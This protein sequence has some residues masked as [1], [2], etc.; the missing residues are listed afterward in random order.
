MQAA[1]GATAPRAKSVLL[2]YTMGGISHHDSFDPKPDAPVEIRGEFGTIPT[3]VPG[4]RFSDYVPRLARQIN[5]YTLLRSIYHSE[6]DHGV[7]AY[8]MLRG[9]R[10]PDPSFD[11]PANQFRANPN[12]GSH[13]ARLLGSRNGLPPYICVPG[14][15]YLAQVHYYTAGW[16]GRAY[17]PYLLKSDP[18]LPTFEVRGLTPRLEVSAARL[19][20]RRSLAQAVDEQYRCFEAAPA[21]R[22]L[23]AQYARAYQVLSTTQA[24]RAF[25]LQAEP[26]KLRDAYGRTR[27][28]Q[29]CLLARR[30]VE[31]GVPFVTVD[32]DG[33]D[34]HA[35][36]FPGLRERLP[37]LDR[38]FTTLLQDLQERGLLKTTLVALLTDFGR[39][40]VINASAGRDHWPGVFSVILTG[41]GIAGG[42]VVGA[43]D[44]IGGEPSQRPLTPKD[45]A[46]TLYHFL[47]I[48]PF[49]EYQTPER[50]PFKMLDEGDVIRELL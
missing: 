30:L 11:L 42:Q 48:D 6:R 44:K 33:W 28:A 45:L 13:V 27:L 36:V 49:Q 18:N 15:S 35:K 17:D 16:M 31:A 22:S 41:A 50:R 19:R 25:D 21:A 5:Q 10:Q 24:R 46:A 23:S 12:I 4:V 32:D 40:P 2:I 3:A 34:H 20:D 37:E 1:G 14:L 39:T 38:C 8:Y 43:S 26:E 47:G 9:Y 29:S 7:S